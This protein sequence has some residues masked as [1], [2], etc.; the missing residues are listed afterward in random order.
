MPKGVNGLTLSSILQA[1]ERLLGLSAEIIGVNQYADRWVPFHAS[2][3]MRGDPDDPI[4]ILLIQG[5]HPIPH[6]FERLHVTAFVNGVRMETY[7]LPSASFV[8]EI[9]L[10][11]NLTYCTVELHTRERFNPY[12]VLGGGDNRDLGFVA[13]LIA[14]ITERELAH[15]KS[16][17]QEE[18]G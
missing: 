4:R 2:I 6:F 9:P 7:E 12:E 15:Y 10:S 5:S 14:P 1:R 3:T 13:E 18:S 16:F 17:I 8:L 11:C